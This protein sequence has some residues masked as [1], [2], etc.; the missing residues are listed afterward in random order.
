MMTQQSSPKSQTLYQTDFYAWTQ[1]QAARLRDED[2]ADLDLDNLIEEI[3]SMGASDKRELASRLTT[4]MEHMLKLVCEP[5]SRARNGWKR[6]VLTQRIGLNRL[7]K[8]NYT[9]RATISDFVDDAYRDA[10]K[11]AASGLGCSIAAL[12]QDC[13]WTAAQLLD[14]DWLPQEARS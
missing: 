11:L 6:T 3:E 7:L 4:I 10:R 5:K 8:S 13:P 14:E 1:Q 2:Y 9:L 12:S